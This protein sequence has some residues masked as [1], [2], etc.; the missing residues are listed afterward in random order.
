[1]LA[2][3]DA[4]AATET[5]MLQ[6]ACG[7]SPGGPTGQGDSEDAIEK[8]V[9]SLSRGALERISG[10]APVFCTFTT[11]IELVLEEFERLLQLSTFGS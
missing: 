2:D 7:W 9:E 10:A 11:A 4:V 3:G 8:S 1:V 6:N 5:V